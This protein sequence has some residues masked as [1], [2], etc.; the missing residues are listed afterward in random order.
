MSSCPHPEVFAFADHGQE[1]GSTCI[2]KTEM[3]DHVL[4]KYLWFASSGGRGLG[5]LE[6]CIWRA[7]S[8]GFI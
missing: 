6:C 3:K 7:F 1:Y 8:S 2:Q 4:Y 5:Y